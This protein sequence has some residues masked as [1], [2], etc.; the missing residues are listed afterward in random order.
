ANHNATARRDVDGPQTRCRLRES[1]PANRQPVREFFRNCVSANSFPVVPASCAFALVRAI[2]AA[3]LLFSFPYESALHKPPTLP[4]DLH[5]PRL[6]RPQCEDRMPSD[7][8]SRRVHPTAREWTLAHR[9]VLGH[10]TPRRWS[11]IGDCGKC[12]AAPSLS[13]NLF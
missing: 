10:C 1:Q 11:A 6:A 4:T 3:L 5:S 13:D 12:P 8:R 9:E 2:S 7:S